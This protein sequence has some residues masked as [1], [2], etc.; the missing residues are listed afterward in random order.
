MPGDRETAGSRVSRP[1]ADRAGARL[2]EIVS[3][4]PGGEELRRVR[5]LAAILET[6]PNA[7]DREACGFYLYHQ[8]GA[9]DYRQAIEAYQRASEVADLCE[10]EQAR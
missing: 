5:A 8:V 3:V 10:Q 2:A 9:P 7:M 4:R 6:T 1:P